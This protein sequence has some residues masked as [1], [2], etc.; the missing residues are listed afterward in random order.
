M[1]MDPRKRQKK[2][3]KQRAKKKAAKRA[4]ARRQA[5]GF[6]AQFETAANS[7]ILHCCMREEL[8]D[9]GIGEVLISRSLPNGNVAFAVFLVD[10]YCLGVKDAWSGIPSRLEY[11]ETLYGKIRR[12]SEIVSVKPAYARKLIEG[13]VQY[14]E[15][16][17]L[18]PHADYRVA[19][20]IFG[21]IS[22][23]SC[24]EQFV[25]G[26]DGKPFFI[27]GPYDDAYRCRHIMKTM[28]SHCGP[29][30]YHYLLSVDDPTS[31]SIAQIDGE[32]NDGLIGPDEDEFYYK[33]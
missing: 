13:A 21:E 33:E 5:Q 2:L 18:S 25:Y 24:T 12:Q 9:K 30:G 1:A 10:V 17:G 3:E 14:A 15:A 7:P 28:E 19:K 23:D 26:H 11:D 4:I 16:I 31:S 8:W 20:L 27:S 6:A 22:T 29:D 32:F